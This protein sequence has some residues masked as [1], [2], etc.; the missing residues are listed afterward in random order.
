MPSKVTKPTPRKFSG[1]PPGGI[2]HA[3]MTQIPRR[4]FSDLLPM[5]DDVAEIKVV[6]FCFWALGQKEGKYKYLRRR[7]FLNDSALMR[8]LAAI[9]AD[10]E[11][12][13]L[14]DAAIERCIERGSLLNVEVML[15]N[16]EETLYFVNTAR[17]REGAQALKSGEWMPGDGSNPVEIIPDRPNAFYLYEEWI[18]ALT[19]MISEELKDAEKEYPQRWLEDAIILAVERNA[20]KWNFIR[21]VLE[22]W[23]REGRDENTGR[24][25]GTDGQAYITG[26]YADYIDH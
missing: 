16:G 18:G 15:D 11:P 8:G 14:L 5:L 9:D 24:P 1:F 26:E 19:P 6:L 13:T 20:R 21:A 2:D 22:R 23:R 7:D 12:K 10:A 17:G 25:D 4:F 3:D